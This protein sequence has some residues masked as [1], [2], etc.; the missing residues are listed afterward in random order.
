MRKLSAAQLIRRFHQL[1]WAEVWQKSKKH[2]K[3][4]FRTK[5]RF[6]R[7][8][9]WV[10]GSSTPTLAVPAKPPLN[11]PVQMTPAAGQVSVAASVSVIIPTLNAGA[12]FETL[13][14]AL[15]NQT[16]CARVEL[17]V[18]DSGSTDGTVSLARQYGA[19]VIQ[20]AASAFSHS[21]AR[22]L[23]AAEA[24]GDYLLFMVQDAM[25]SGSHWLSSFVAGVERLQVAA[26]SCVETPRADADLL[27][28]ILG[29]GHLEFMQ[30][31]SADRVFDRLV[32]Q[33]YEEV[34]R[35]C[36]LN[37]VACLIERQVFARHQFKG[38]FAE[39]LDLGRRLAQAGERLGLLN[40]VRVVHSHNRP[41][42]YHL[43][44][45]F[46]DGMSMAE[47]FDD[48]P[49]PPAIEPGRLGQEAWLSFGA[50]AQALES[51]RLQ[52]HFPLSYIE[53]AARVLTTFDRMLSADAPPDLAAKMSTEL[54]YVDFL[55]RLAASAPARTNGKLKAAVFVQTLRGAL[56]YA[57]EFLER[58]GA[59][60]DE[61]LLRSLGEYLQK[62]HALQLGAYL[63]SSLAGQAENA[64]F[65][66]I[67][68]ELRQGV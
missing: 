45:G 62:A 68:R 51:L 52:F 39:D 53:F 15:V 43:K 13:L 42:Y 2:L 38:A 67:A 50:Q 11:A 6:S 8:G 16:G 23:G 31:A 63:A 58:E 47:L 30:A 44:R 5:V 24:T 61:E 26:A 3:W 25:P 18:V 17:I 56:L 49:P 41:A 10:W 54:A 66:W 60:A 21:H 59:I 40:S 37:N 33:S 65:G 36:Q 9:L 34:R 32:N 28:R 14:A 20:L 22:N 64:E 57:L 55:A 48:Y 19:Q 1:G 27:A 46:V 35:N 29:Q 7:W 12:E 4:Q